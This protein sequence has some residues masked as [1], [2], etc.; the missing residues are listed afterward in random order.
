MVRMNS[1]LEWGGV[2]CD[3]SSAEIVCP[4]S[5]PQTPPQKQYLLQEAAASPCVR[6]PREHTYLASPTS[7]ET[8]LPTGKVSVHIFFDNHVRAINPSSVRYRSL[9]HRTFSR[10]HVGCEK[11]IFK[12]GAHMDAAPGEDLFHVP[13]DHHDPTY[14]TTRADRPVG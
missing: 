9:M 5:G 3:V 4:F 7:M 12:F 6:L 1:V 13:S 8:V 14:P 10:T 2:L 11:M